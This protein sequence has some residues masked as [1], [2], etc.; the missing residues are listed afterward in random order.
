MKCC[1]LHESQGRMRVHFC[2]GRMTL[3]Q[4]DVAE[5]YLRSIGGALKVSRS[6]TEPV[7]PSCVTPANERR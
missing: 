5:Y 7:M 6:S 1:I 2:V 4:A 3:R